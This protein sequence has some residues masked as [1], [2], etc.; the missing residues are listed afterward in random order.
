MSDMNEPAGV[1]KQEPSTAAD[2]RLP[3]HRRGG[4]P[5]MLRRENPGS[6]RY[7]RATAREPGRTRL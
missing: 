7:P 1:S 3:N 4:V 6:G 5:S 2:L